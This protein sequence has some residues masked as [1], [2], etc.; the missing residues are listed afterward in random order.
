MRMDNSNFY[1]M[2]PLLRPEYIR[3]SIKDI[4]DEIIRECDLTSIINDNGV[5]YIE[6]NRGMYGPP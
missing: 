1:L 3:V 5:I 6:A 4:P 2:T